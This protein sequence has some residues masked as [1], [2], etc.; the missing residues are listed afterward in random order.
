[1]AVVLLCKY[2]LSRRCGDENDNVTDLK[3]MPK[4]LRIFA[5]GLLVFSKETSFMRDSL[6]RFY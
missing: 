4:Y 3:K 5:S 6:N 2:Y 1:M